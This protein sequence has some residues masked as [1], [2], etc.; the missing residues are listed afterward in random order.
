ME[1]INIKVARLE[2]DI[3]NLKAEQKE[4]KKSIV[5]INKLASSVEVLVNEMKH[6][7]EKI[8]NINSKVELHHTEEPNKL[9]YKTKE[10]I[11]AAV[12]SAVVGAIITIILK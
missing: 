5:Y 7:N 4:M 6:M 3:E 12:V 10:V 1:D 9:I 8:D 11:V 2:K